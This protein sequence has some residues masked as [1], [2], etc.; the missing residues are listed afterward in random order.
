MHPVT[1]LEANLFFTWKKPSSKLN[2]DKSK[3]FRNCF[4]IVTVSNMSLH[5]TNHI[6]VMLRKLFLFPSCMDLELQPSI[7]LQQ[8]GPSSFM[9][10]ARGNWSSYCTLSSVDNESEHSVPI[11][12]FRQKKR[13]WKIWFDFTTCYTWSSNLKKTAKENIGKWKNILG[14]GNF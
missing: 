9:P 12:K 8:I 4:M 11:L 6:R 10:W 13:N 7:S 2:I 5:G 1:N 14:V 3:R